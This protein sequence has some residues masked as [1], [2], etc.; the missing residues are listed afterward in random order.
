MVTS[1]KIDSFM[2]VTTRPVAHSGQFVC[3]PSC[4]GEFGM[5]TGQ[6]LVT[7]SGMS[8]HLSDHHKV[9]YTYIKM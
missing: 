7:S 3:I 9:Y 1:T 4:V 8:N 5:Y 2:L 6:P